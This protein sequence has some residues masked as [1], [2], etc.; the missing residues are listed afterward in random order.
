MPSWLRN[1]AQAYAAPIAAVS[2]ISALG[3]VAAPALAGNP[4]LLVALAPRLP[5]LLLAAHRTPALLLLVVATARL[6]VTDVHYFALG[7]RW[8]PAATERLQRLRSRWRLP[9]WRR[10]PWLPARST[11]IL[12]VL[13]RPV[14]RHVA[15]AGAGGASPVSVAIADVAGT[16]AY[17]VAVVWVGDT[18]W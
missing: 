18:I 2:L 7:R 1:E 13:I 11:A 6:C 14:G 12:A 10:P 3:T 9:S 8:G 15:L 5:F 4:L 16:V 17:V